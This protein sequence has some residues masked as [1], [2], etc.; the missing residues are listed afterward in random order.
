[1]NQKF[2]TKMANNSIIINK[3]EYKIVK[4]LGKGGFG[5]VYQVL[6]KSNNKYYAIKE[7]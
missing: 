4:E 7:I 3:I 1:M 6:N 5:K 2:R